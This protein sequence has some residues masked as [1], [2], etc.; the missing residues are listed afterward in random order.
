MGNEI[1]TTKNM[2]TTED[3][4]H[5]ARK[6]K[7]LVRGF[8][9]TTRNFRKNVSEPILPL[10]ASTRSAG[11]DFPLPNDLTLKPNEQKTI[12]LDIKAY[13][14]DGEYLALYPRSSAGIKLEL[15]LA[16]TVG[17]IDPDYYDNENT[18]GNIGLCIKNTSDKEVTLDRGDRVIQ[19]VFQPFLVS[20]NCNSTEIRTG[21][22]G[23][24][25]K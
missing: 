17:I 7:L 22:T 20:D 5:R 16:N 1:T 3:I 6:I 23:S 9:V 13:M 12:W 4:T 19:G 18:G 25:G 15:R 21:G 10:R 2:F 8:E 24:T 11:Y 14:K